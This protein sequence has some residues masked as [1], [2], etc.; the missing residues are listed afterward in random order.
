[1]K[2]WIPVVTVGVGLAGLIL[3]LHAQTQDQLAGVG[4]DIERLDD[5]LTVRI[6][7]LDE[8]VYEL[9]ERL[10]RVETRILEAVQQ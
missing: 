3:V 10:A 2:D 6:E 5:R 4:T 8:R 1:M 9:N 7:S